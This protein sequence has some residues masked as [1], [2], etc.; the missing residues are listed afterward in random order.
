MK[1]YEHQQQAVDEILGFYALGDGNVVL[2]APTSFGKSLVIAEL[3]KQL[4]GHIVILVTFTALIQ[5]I[6]EHLDELGV[7][8]SIIKAGMDDKFDPNK[9]VQLAMKQTLYARMD[10]LD[11]KCDYMIKDE[12]HVEWFGQKRM[13][14]VYQYLGEPNIVGLSAT[15]YSSKGYRLK[16]VEMI[17]RTKGVKELTDD[18]YLAPVK[19][20]IPKFAQLV[21]YTKFSK[22]T[23]D[24]KEEDIDSV[25]LDPEYMDASIDAMMAMNIKDKKSIVFCNSIEHADAVAK[26]LSDN[27]VKA[28]AFHSKIDKLRSDS[29][30]NSFRSNAE[31]TMND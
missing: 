22:S 15:P 28:Y 6:S 17:I 11:I 29:I 20:Y 23:G 13:D 10:K 19:Y 24:Y 16:D 3:A 25:V 5:Q 14:S 21:D 1:L 9:R 27:G 8:H 18:G 2:E 26:Q 12:V 30:L 4:D 31:V 7:D